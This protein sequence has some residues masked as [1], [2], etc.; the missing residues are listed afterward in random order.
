M[1]GGLISTQTDHYCRR[2]TIEGFLC[3]DWWQK[4]R[5]TH[6]HSTTTHNSTKHASVLLLFLHIPQ[7]KEGKK[8]CFLLSL[9]NFAFSVGSTL[10]D[11]SGWSAFNHP[12]HKHWNLTGCSDILFFDV[13]KKKKKREEGLQF[14]S[15]FRGGLGI[16]N[17][18]SLIVGLLRV[19]HGSSAFICERE[20][21]LCIINAGRLKRQNV[22]IIYRQGTI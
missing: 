11:V 21:R 3:N 2:H 4:H 12:N 1:Q 5:F 14:I 10:Q 15:Q 9:L 6:Q 8:N 16:G 7:K 22:E 18:M 13:K 19:E 17:D 20:E